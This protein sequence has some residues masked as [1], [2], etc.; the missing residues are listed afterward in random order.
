[1]SGGGRNG[2]H[3]LVSP[4]V[5]LSCDTKALARGSDAVC[6]CINDMMDGAT[7]ERLAQ[8]RNRIIAL[9]L[10]GAQAVRKG[11][12]FGRHM[13][14]G[15]KNLV[16]VTRRLNRLRGRS[17][18]MSRQS[19]EFCIQGG[20]SSPTTAKNRGAFSGRAAPS[21]ES[22]HPHASPEKAGDADRAG[23]GPGTKGW[24]PRFRSTDCFARRNEE[25]GRVR[26]AETRIKDAISAF[27]LFRH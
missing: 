15:I 17:P 3:G 11:A 12:P 1:M 21:R 25:V 22:C 18:V 7:V 8:C 2:G 27:R 16:R 24:L 13:P 14:L 23:L 9:H 26:V 5:R 6:A 20:C 10:A 19:H 4:D